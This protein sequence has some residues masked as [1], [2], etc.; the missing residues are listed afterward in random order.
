MTAVQELRPTP[1]KPS[2][3]LFRKLLTDDERVGL[4]F[5]FGTDLTSRAR[6]VEQE[7]PASEARQMYDRLLGEGYLKQPMTGDHFSRTQ[8]LAAPDS[9]IGSLHPLG[10]LLPREDV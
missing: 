3:V 8:S 9:E 10:L 2:C 7:L 6:I 1:V 5:V 4:V